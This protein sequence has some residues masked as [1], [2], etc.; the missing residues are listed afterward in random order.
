MLKEK[1]QIHGKFQ[2]YFWLLCFILGN[3]I[4]KSIAFKTNE[5]AVDIIDQNLEN[6]SNEE[7]FQDEMEEE[8][9]NKD[10]IDEDEQD[11]ID[12]DN[13]SKCEDNI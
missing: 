1:N 2:K 10:E 8:E 4:W 7:E 6:S 12:E 13:L 5:K 11:E 3:D 9:G